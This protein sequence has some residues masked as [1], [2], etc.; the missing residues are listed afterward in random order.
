[1]RSA[2][3]TIFRHAEPNGSN[4]GSR[5]LQWNGNFEG[6][7]LAFS[8]DLELFFCSLNRKMIDDKDKE[9]KD[10]AKEKLC[11]YR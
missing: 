9:I 8:W 3:A 7:I 5:M 2:R 6:H 10:N 11:N 4:C 1:V